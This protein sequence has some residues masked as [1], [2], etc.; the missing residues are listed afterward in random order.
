LGSSIGSILSVGKTTE[1]SV[2]PTFA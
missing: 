1:V 2:T